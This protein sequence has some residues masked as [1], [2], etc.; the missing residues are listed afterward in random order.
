MS[1]YEQKPSD[2]LKFGFLTITEELG[3]LLHTTTTT[4]T[5]TTS[6]FYCKIADFCNSTYFRHFTVE[7]HSDKIGFLIATLDLTADYFWV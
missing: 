5:T 6:D 7:L 4:T 2:A 1:E 3:I